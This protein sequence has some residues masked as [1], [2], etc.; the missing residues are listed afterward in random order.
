MANFSLKVM[1]QKSK[2][3]REASTGF[4][5]PPDSEMASGNH[6]GKYSRERI[7]MSLVKRDEGSK[8]NSNINVT[9]PWWT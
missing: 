7:T 5:P 2:L 3:S 9:P 4:A 8:V 6:S 1:L